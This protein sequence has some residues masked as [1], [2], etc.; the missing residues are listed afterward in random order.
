M[1]SS[2]RRPPSPRRAEEL[3]AEARHARERRDLYRAKVYGP[4]PTSSARLKELERIAT[5]SE[6]RAR[7]S[8]QAVRDEA[9]TAAGAD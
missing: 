5:V 9:G 3:R 6:R 7:R 2:L 8:E 1:T 4:R